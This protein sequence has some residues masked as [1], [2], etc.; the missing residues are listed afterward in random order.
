MAGGAVDLTG[1]LGLLG[2]GCLACCLGRL[3]QALTKSHI[4][5]NSQQKH[6]NQYQPESLHSRFLFHGADRSSKNFLNPG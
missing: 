5:D 1:M 4:G 3:D 6:K 2:R